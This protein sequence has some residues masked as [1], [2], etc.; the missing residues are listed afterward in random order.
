[1]FYED[2]KVQTFASFQELVPLNTQP[3][4]IARKEIKK[5][6]NFLEVKFITLD[7]PRTNIE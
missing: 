1:M 4:Q 6:K 2:S 3:V 5:N 7:I